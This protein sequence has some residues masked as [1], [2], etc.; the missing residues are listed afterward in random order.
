M[1]K[2]IMCLGEQFRNF[3]DMI[4]YSR[5]HC[6]SYAQARMHAAEIVVGEMQRD[7]GFQVHYFLLK[8]F[9]RRVKRR[10]AIRIVRFWRSTKLVEM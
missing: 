9:V 5:F 10:I 8:A 1:S 4:G 3:P 6:G 7:G 2:R